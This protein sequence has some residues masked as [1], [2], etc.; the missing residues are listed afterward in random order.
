MVFPR[1]TSATL[2]GYA[3]PTST[4]GAA[5]VG[6][7][8]PGRAWLVANGTKSMPGA[9]FC[10]AQSYSI[11]ETEFLISVLQMRN[12]KVT[13]VKKGICLESQN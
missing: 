10:H 11:R 8:R 4:G 1:D 7:G 6:G 3:V 12:A 5:N 9:P 13:E 2:E